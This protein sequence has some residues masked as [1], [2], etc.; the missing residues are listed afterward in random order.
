MLK[1]SVFLQTQHNIT[2]FLNKWP[3]GDPER[4]WSHPHKQSISGTATV[5]LHKRPRQP[6]FVSLCLVSAMQQ[7]IQHVCVN[8]IM[9]AAHFLAKSAP[10]APHCACAHWRPTIWQDDRGVD[11]ACAVRSFHSQSMRDQ[12]FASTVSLI[13]R[14]LLKNNLQAFTTILEYCSERDRAP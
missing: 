10:A 1:W 11:G 12:Y 6:K 9:N 5:P 13:P 2:F 14:L 8:A 4:I 3:A 7:P